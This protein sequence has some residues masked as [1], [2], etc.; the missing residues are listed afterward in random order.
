MEVVTYGKRKYVLGLRWVE[1]DSTRKPAAQVKAA[2]DGAK[3]VY[4]VQEGKD[5]RAVVGYGSAAKL[6]AG[7]L[8]SYAVTLAS[9][10][11]DGI[12][13]MPAGRGMLW[14]VVVSE[15]AVVPETDVLLAFE[16]GLSAIENMRSA[17]GLPVYYGGKE[18]M[19][20]CEEFRP[21]VI[22]AAAMRQKALVQVGGAQVGGALVLAGVVLG[23]IGGGWWLL[24]KRGPSPEEQAAEQAAQ[25]RAA[26]L[27]AMHAI[28]DATP[29][30][31]GWVQDALAQAQA[32]FPVAIAGW[33]RDG[34]AC[35]VSACVATYSGGDIQQFAPVA[36]AFGPRAR[37]GADPTRQMTITLPLQTKLRP[38]TDEQILAPAK[39][40]RS[41][42]DV[43]G[44]LPLH[45]DAK[46]ASNPVSTDISTSL[47][48][49]PEAQPV[50]E[51]VLV[52]KRDGPVVAADLAGVVNAVAKDGFHAH[53]LSVAEAGMGERAYRV[54]FWRFGAQWTP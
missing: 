4:V 37:L 32:H 23:V 27:A 54:E 33:S 14:Y 43:A 48:P 39:W 17:F 52:L 30:D 16:D 45:F 8:Y 42:Y 38:W 7:A 47:A 24:H 51:D 50:F 36:A 15:G 20:E 6:G 13:A 21:E 46:L 25:V 31:S 19:P 40:S 11:K 44:V 53:T 28:V 18:P 34:F 3:S 41:L 49:P 2:T 22:A 12:Y 1:A 9:T 5:G 29:Q 26:Y 10:G 35:D